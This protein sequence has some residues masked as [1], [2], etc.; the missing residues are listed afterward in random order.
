MPSPDL[1]PEVGGVVL[2]DAIDFFPESLRRRLDA[3]QLWRYPRDVTV[4]SLV[5]SLRGRGHMALAENVL[6]AA[7][8]WLNT[9]TEGG[10]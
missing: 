4:S 3:A 9:Q 6:Y 7:Q 2:Y 5:G 1:T 8:W 10:R